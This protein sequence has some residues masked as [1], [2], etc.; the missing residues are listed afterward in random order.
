MAALDLHCCMQAFSSCGEWGVPVWFGNVGF[1]L[2]PFFLLQ[3]M[4]S[5]VLAQ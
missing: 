2:Q 5:R 4:G 1:S 3:G